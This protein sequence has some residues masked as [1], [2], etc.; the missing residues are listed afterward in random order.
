[1]RITSTPAEGAA[2]A[3]PRVVLIGG[4]G[5]V[6]S[7]L[8]RRLLDRR[9]QVTVLDA[10]VYGDEGIRNLYARSA[11]EV[12]RADLRDTKIIAR[13]CQGAATVV[14]LGGLGRRPCLRA[15]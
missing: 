14:H 8:A 11:F 5:F 3:L 1:M 2:S 12:V 9:Y 13:S 6:G 4:A 7:V 15:R 10:L